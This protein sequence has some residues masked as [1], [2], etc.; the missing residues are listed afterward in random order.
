[1][2]FSQVALKKIKVY[3]FLS[4]QPSFLGAYKWTAWKSGV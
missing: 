3:L 1:M 2:E 4:I